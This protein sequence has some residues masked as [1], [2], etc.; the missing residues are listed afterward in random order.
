MT[1]LDIQNDRDNR[2]KI[3]YNLILLIYK[4][5]LLSQERRDTYFCISTTFKT[6]KQFTV[7]LVGKQ[8][9]TQ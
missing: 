8:K 2:Q 9:I 6:A 4:R 5:T 3:S 1:H 7:N